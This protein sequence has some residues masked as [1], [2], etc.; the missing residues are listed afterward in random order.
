ME[1]GDATALLKHFRRQAKLD[2]GFF[3]EVEVDVDENIAS[4]F[5]ADGKMRMDY[6]FFGDSVSFDTTYRTNKEYRPLALFVGFNN[7]HQL[8][9]FGAALLYDETTATFEWLFNQFLE[10]MG[11]VSPLSIFTDQAAA[12]AAGIRSVFPSSFHG[13]CSWHISQNAVVNLG[14]LCDSDFLCELSYLMYNVDDEDDFEYNW[15]RM[16]DKCFPGKGPLGHS[17]LQ[18]IYKVREKWSSAWVNSHFGAGMKSTQLSE[19]C[20]SNLRHYLQSEFSI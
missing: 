10:C 5:W 12:I 20:N 7:H 13:L 3:H 8:T 9:V 1:H 19:C 11:G 16:I 18:G 15:K 17:W 6:H 4:I 2:P 14:S